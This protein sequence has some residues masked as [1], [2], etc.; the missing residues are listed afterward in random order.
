MSAHRYFQLLFTVSGLLLQSCNEP[1]TNPSTYD[2]PKLPAQLRT[3]VHLAV[4]NNYTWRVWQVG[5][6]TFFQWSES[7]AVIDD[8]TLGGKVHF[9]FDSG[10]KLRSSGDTV[11]VY[12]NGSDSVDYRL[13]VAVGDT[14]P[15]IGY[16]FRVTTVEREEVLGDSQTVVTVSNHLGAS[17]DVTSG[18]YA[19]KFGIIQIERSHP[20][21]VTTSRLVAARLGTGIYP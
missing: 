17:T 5:I 14:V 11:I 21:H 10:E 13:N 3:P 6:G 2:P 19:S 15:F 4:G 18:R 16:S 7:Y 1:S 12:A 20:Q 8:T 9:V